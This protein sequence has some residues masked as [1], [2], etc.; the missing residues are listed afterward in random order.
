VRLVRGPLRRRGPH[1]RRRPAPGGDLARLVERGRRPRFHQGRVAAGG[2]GPRRWRRGSPHARLRL[3]LPRTPSATRLQ[4]RGAARGDVERPQRAR[5]PNRRRHAR[6]PAHA[7]QSRRRGPGRAGGDNGCRGRAV[8]AGVAGHGG[9]VLRTGLSRGRDRFPMAGSHV[10]R[11]RRSP[12]ADAGGGD[13]R[14][15]GEPS[16]RTTALRTAGRGP[17]LQEQPD[18]FPATGRPASHG[19]SETG[20]G[21]GGAGRAEVPGAGGGAPHGR[22]FA[23]GR[24]GPRRRPGDHGLLRSLARGLGGDRSGNG[25]REAFAPSLEPCRDEARQLPR[26]A[27]DGPGPP[28]RRPPA[29]RPVQSFPVA[30]QHQPSRGAAAGGCRPAQ[31]PGRHIHGA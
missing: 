18:A 9:Q 23:G 8:R 11:G 24:R 19:D 7:E 28:V 20:R 15:A 26:Q 2:G 10:G 13:R 4:R 27:S 17:R 29:Q 12:A 21:P 3:V 22:R 16:P 5:R 31:R 1:H 6:P 30:G 25:A 14:A